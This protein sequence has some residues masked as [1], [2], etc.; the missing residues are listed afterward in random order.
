[1]SA[2]NQP[3]IRSL[4]KRGFF[5][6]HIERPEPAGGR[7]AQARTCSPAALRPWVPSLFTFYLLSYLKRHLGLRSQPGLDGIAQLWNH[8]GFH[9]TRMST[10]RTSSSRVFR[11]ETLVETKPRICTSLCPSK[12]TGLQHLPGLARDVLQTISKLVSRL[13][14]A[15][16]GRDGEDDLR[17]CWSGR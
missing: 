6:E 15:K 13:S 5:P 11:R 3:K 8:L 4:S 2:G 12:V 1:M 16:L 9:K 17:L 14:E 7:L 10:W